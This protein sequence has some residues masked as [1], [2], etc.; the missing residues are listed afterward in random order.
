MDV[1]DVEQI[2]KQAIASGLFKDDNEIEQCL[3]A[4]RALQ[5]GSLLAAMTGKLDANKI[6]N[7]MYNSLQQLRIIAGGSS[8]CQVTFPDSVAQLDPILSPLA[9]T[10]TP[11]QE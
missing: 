2:R 7:V 11:M 6:A 8:E 5:N 1:T 3:Q 10:A 9:P 4:R